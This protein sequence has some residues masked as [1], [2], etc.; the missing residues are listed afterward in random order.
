MKLFG[1]LGKEKPVPFPQFRDIVRLAMRRSHPGATAQNSDN[2]FVLTLNG[3]SHNCNLRQLYNDYCKTPREREALIQRYLDTFVTNL[4]PPEH[5]WLEA[6]HLLRPMVK[7]IEAIELTR[8]EMVKNKSTDTLPSAPFTGELGVIVVRELPG[9]VVA[10]TQKQLEAWGVSFEQ[11]MHE[12]VNNMNMLSFPPITNEL[13]IGGTAKRGVHDGEV[14]GL[15]FEGDHLTATW[16]TLERFRD[17]LG[18]RLQGDYVVSV[19]N[20]SRLVAVRVDE[21]GMIASMQQSNRTFRNMPY[22]L[23]AQCYHVSAASTGGVVSIYE[24]VGSTTGGLDPNSIF[25]SGAPG[26]GPLTTGMPTPGVNRPGPINFGALG[27]LSEPTADMPEPTPKSGHK[28][29]KH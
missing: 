7:S 20:R 12:A 13:F 24:G 26:T 16:L 14:V 2:G 15:V 9:S 27:G 6:R 1:M 23:T 3:K 29:G 10:V 11:A 17:Y 25:A 21:P 18:M 4:E 5:G 28:R 22:G 19:P 8:K